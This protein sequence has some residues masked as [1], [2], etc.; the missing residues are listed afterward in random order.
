MMVAA[1]LLFMSQTA[2]LATTAADGT[3][4]LTVL[5]FDRMGA[6]QVE[7]WRITWSG[8]EAKDFWQQQ[9]PSL[10][11]GQPLQ[12]TLERL[13]TFTTSHRN[14]GPEFVARAIDIELAPL[15]HPPRTSPCGAGVTSY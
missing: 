7:P 10:K 6:H 14:G 9:G 5:A 8:S 3:F 13:R 11:A 15:A 12:V 1:G 4:A 2:P